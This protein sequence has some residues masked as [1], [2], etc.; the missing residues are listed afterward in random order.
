M[1]FMAAQRIRKPSYEKRLLD[2]SRVGVEL[3]VGLYYPVNNV[4]LGR[5]TKFALLSAIGVSDSSSSE[6]TLPIGL[7]CQEGKRFF[8]LVLSCVCVMVCPYSSL[9]SSLPSAIAGCSCGEHR[10]VSQQ[11]LLHDAWHNM[12][13]SLSGHLNTIV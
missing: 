12:K 4:L 8:F 13:F 3:L 9:Y 6:S 10:S 7:L 2:N 5:W 11:L 1:V